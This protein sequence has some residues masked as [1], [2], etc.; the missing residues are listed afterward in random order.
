MNTK[1]LMIASSVFMAL[2]GIVLIFGPDETL[3]TLGQ[4]PNTTL[5][6]ILQLT[7]ALYF[8]FA[9]I[10]WMAKTVLIGGIYAKP[11]SVG[12]FSH[13]LI[14]G[15]ALIK[16]SMNSSMANTYIYILTAF[17]AMFA[18]L[19]GYVFITNPKLKQTT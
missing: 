1:F 19:F 10:N 8:G 13:F 12:N 6:L 3:K 14:A 16:V 11:L 7:G 15:L 5:D 18:I 2:I 9:M 17:Y 4:A